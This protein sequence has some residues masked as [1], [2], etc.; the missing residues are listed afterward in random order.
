M[1]IVLSTDDPMF[2]N[3]GSNDQCD[4]KR[5]PGSNPIE[6][7]AKLVVEIGDGYEEIFKQKHQH[8]P[9]FW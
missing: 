9:E 8:E 2:Q 3:D 6:R 1:C 4:R 5:N 7:V